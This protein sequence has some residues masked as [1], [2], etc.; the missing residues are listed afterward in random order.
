MISRRQPAVRAAVFGLLLTAC[1]G[2]RPA[3]SFETSE[4]EDLTEGR[5]TEICLEVAADRQLTFETGWVVNLGRGA[6]VP[7]D[8][9]VA[10]TE[11]GLEWVTAADRSTHGTILP[12]PATEDQLV[13]AGG[14][15]EDSE[16]QV[17]VLDHRSY[18]FHPDPDA[19]QRGATGVREVEARLARD[20]R[21][22]L[23][24]VESVAPLPS[25]G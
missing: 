20:V 25:P 23:T 4:F 22:F 13:L 2:H 3:V 7:V 21:E 9:R 17:L 15:G 19:V 24:H 5:A 8:L 11:F 12:E 10:G 16:A 1:G 6:A 14:A 18:R